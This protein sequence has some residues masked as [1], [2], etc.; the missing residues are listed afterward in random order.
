MSLNSSSKTV[1]RWFLKGRL[2]DGSPWTIPIQLPR[3]IIGRSEE[4]S[5][6]LD[7]ME[8]SRRHAAIHM[9]NSDL[10]VS[11]LGSRNG[12]FLNGS[13]VEGR[14]II[15][16]RDILKIGS[17]EFLVTVTKRPTSESSH[18]VVEDSGNRGFAGRFGLSAREEEILYLLVRGDSIQE[19]A[20][21]LFIA[22]GT[23]KNHVL[24]IYKKTDCHSKIE[25]AN[26]YREYT[27]S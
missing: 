27:K 9:E 1:V 25:I 26:K 23:A 11:D 4:C 2:A 5:L 13:V 20:R 10:F 15:E 6:I 14:R 12:T 24:K 18:T 22:P 17:H 8:V 3:F 21:K 16:D 19:I 7:S